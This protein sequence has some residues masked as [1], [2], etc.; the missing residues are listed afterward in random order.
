MQDI[1][2]LVRL[3]KVLKVKFAFV[4]SS[5]KE[6]DVIVGEYI[7]R[8]KTGTNDNRPAFQQMLYDSKQKLL[9]AF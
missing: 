9:K 6:M 2:V 7:D 1:Q 8:A 4:E 3:R 5:L